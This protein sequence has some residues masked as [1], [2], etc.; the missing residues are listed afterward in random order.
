MHCSKIL[1]IISKCVIINIKKLLEAWI[2]ACEPH[3]C[4]I[5]LRFE[6]C[7][8]PTSRSE[9]FCQLGPC[10]KVLWSAVWKRRQEIVVVWHAHLATM[11][12]LLHT[13]LKP[14]KRKLSC[15]LAPRQL[16]HQTTEQ[17]LVS[18]STVH[19][20]WCNNRKKLKF[21]C[22]KYGNSLFVKASYLCP[23]HC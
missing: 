2:F 20:V 7:L 21:I 15:H 22:Y 11:Q 12:L 17:W 5:C 16:F 1:G 18:N 4:W 10:Q 3:M 14:R 8:Q 19:P 9:M 13:M 6:F 23:R